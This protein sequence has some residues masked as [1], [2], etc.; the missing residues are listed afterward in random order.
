MKLS[1]SHDSLVCEQC[2][3][4]GPIA[5][6]V[7]EMMRRAVQEQGFGYQWE[8]GSLYHTAHFYCPSC[9]AEF[10]CEASK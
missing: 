9:K 10:D 2:G 5:D 1:P 3:K 6:T 4:P 7:Q 8:H